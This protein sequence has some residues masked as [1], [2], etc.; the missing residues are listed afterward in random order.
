MQIGIITVKDAEYHPNRRLKQAAK[1][2]GVVLSRLNPYTWMPEIINQKMGLNRGNSLLMP[3]IIIPRQGAQVSDSS[4]TVLT[5]FNCM[6]IPFI[7]DLNSILITRNQYLTLQMLTCAGISVPN[8]LFLN[9]TQHLERAVKILGGFPVVIKPTT[10]RQG[11]G[12][13]LVKSAKTA[14]Q[15]IKSCLDKSKGVLV[16][17]YIPPEGRK[18]IR[19]FVIGGKIAGAILLFPENNDF[20]ANYHLTGKAENFDLAYNGHEQTRL[21]TDSPTTKHESREKLA[22]FHIKIRQIAIAAAKAVGLEIA[23][24][25]IIVDHTGEPMVLE[26]NYSPGF[27]GLEKT[28]GLDIAGMIIDYT[29]SALNHRL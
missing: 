18:D 25:D 26:V 24:V 28:T 7:N 17:Q 29:I 9:S 8:T 14:R 12:V 20:R 19:V 16:Q 15:F 22:D 13:T 10:G 4:L 11:K 1:Q 6:E 3:D 21:D 27:K 23:G 5:H 2:R